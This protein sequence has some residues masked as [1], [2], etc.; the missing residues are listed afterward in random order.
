MR[1]IVVKQYRD[2]GAFQQDALRQGARG[3]EIIEVNGQQQRVAITRTAINTLLTGGMGLVIGGRAHKGNTVMVTYQYA[4]KEYAR[5]RRG[6][7]LLR[8]L[9]VLLLIAVVTGGLIVLVLH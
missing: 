5:I 4:G 1:P 9:P 6:G 2:S 8:I 3:Y 7:Y